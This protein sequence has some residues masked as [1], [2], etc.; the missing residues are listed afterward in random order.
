[1]TAP[2]NSCRFLRNPKI[3]QGSAVLLSC[4]VGFGMALSTIHGGPGH[5]SGFCCWIRVGGWAHGR[6]A[7]DAYCVIY[8][9][10]L[11]PFYLPKLGKV[12]Q[13][14]ITEFLH[15]KFFFFLSFSKNTEQPHTFFWGPLPAL[16][17]PPPSVC[18][19]RKPLPMGAH[20]QAC[21]YSLTYSMAWA[22]TPV[23]HSR[24]LI[25]S[26]WLPL[27]PVLWMQGEGHYRWAQ[28]WIK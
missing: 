25:G 18:Y 15:L 12:N 17:A 7:Q 1:M 5:F 4:H 14:A 11:F 26:Q 13:G 19:C 28:R 20:I 16:M 6:K 9:S 3:A 23:L 24:D 8:K 2:R 10:N 21:V 22:P 27:L